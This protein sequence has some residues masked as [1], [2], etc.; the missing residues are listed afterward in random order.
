MAARGDQFSGMTDREP[1]R[2]L[3]L[4]VAVDRTAP[5]TLSAQIEEHVRQAVRAGHLRPGTRLPSTRDLAR[6]VS[7]SRRVVV[8]AYAQLAAEGYVV[9]R[10]GAAPRVAAATVLPLPDAPPSREVRSAP[11]PRFDFRPS[12]PDVSTFPRQAWG[13]LLR[14]ATATIPDAEL[15]YGDPCG[16]DTLRAA[17]AEYLGRVRGV[18]AGPR[19]VVVT[20]GYLQ[21]FGLACRVLADRGAVRLALEDPSAPEQAPIARRAGLVPVAVPVDDGGLVV[22]ALDDVGA[23]AVVV[24]AAHQHPT[25]VVLAPERRRA[26]IGWLQRHDAYAIED[27]YDAEYR[28]DRAPVKALQGMAPDRILYAGSASKT[29]AP[30]LR[31][32]WMTVPDRLQRAFATEKLLADQGSARIEQHAMAQLIRSGEL[33]RHLRKMRL[34]YRARRDALIDALGE[35]LPTATVQGIAAGLHVCVVLDERYDEVAVRAEAAARRVE[36]STISDYT[37]GA[38]ATRPMLLLGYAQVPV[39]G[40]RAGVQ[41]LVAALDAARSP[42]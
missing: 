25:G 32:G 1:S 22:D 24:T 16:V 9:L 31:L 33:D 28:Y 42:E 37:P 23:D 11:V 38:F 18:A 6:Q 39:A 34:R 15:I 26:L 20:T 5:A 2:P 7:V 40:M 19:D 36:L 13:R 12:R 30:A 29:L 10:Q 4:A 41:E 35:L 14:E 17:L 3:E 21:A 8:E 27:D